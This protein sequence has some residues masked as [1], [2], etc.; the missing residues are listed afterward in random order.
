MLLRRLLYCQEDKAT[1]VG[2]KKSDAREMQNFYQ[3]YYAK[4]IEA[5][6]NATDKAD[7]LVSFQHFYPYNFSDCSKGVV[8]LLFFP[9]FI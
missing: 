7:R 8:G 9:Y 6:Q 3:H 1:I 2:R 5:L 4:Y